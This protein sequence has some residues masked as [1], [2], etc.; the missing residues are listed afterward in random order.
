MFMKKNGRKG[1]FLLFYSYLCL[2]FQDLIATWHKKK[3]EY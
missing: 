1:V 2:V 3:K